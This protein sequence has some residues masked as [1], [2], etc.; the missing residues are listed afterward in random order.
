MSCAI[1]MP[2]LC[3]CIAKYFA[4]VPATQVEEIVTGLQLMFHS[5]YDFEVPTS[6]LKIHNRTNSD[7][8]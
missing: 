8:M 5:L 6:G 2:I 1:R 7:V 3:V 4:R